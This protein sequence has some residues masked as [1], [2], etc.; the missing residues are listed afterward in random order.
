[1]KSENTTHIAYWMCSQP[2]FNNLNIPKTI[3]VTQGLICILHSFS[4][5]ATY[6]N[7]KLNRYISLLALCVLKQASPNVLCSCG[8]LH[9]LVPTGKAHLVGFEGHGML[10]FYSSEIKIKK[11]ISMKQDMRSWYIYTMTNNLSK[12]HLKS[13]KMCSEM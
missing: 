10:L 11:G 4:I 7:K 1:M 9:V 2:T 3:L 6:K 13:T 5:K 8:S 12:L